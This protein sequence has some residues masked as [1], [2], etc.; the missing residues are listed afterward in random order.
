[1]QQ[2]T[3]KMKNSVILFIAIVFSLN[4][5]G[6]DTF[7]ITAVDTITGE[8]GSAGAS[9][10]GAPQIPMGCRILSDV[11]PGKGVIHTQAYYLSQNQNYARQLMLAGYSPEQ[12]IDSL[13]A[14]DWQ[15][16]PTIRQYGV[17][18]LYDGS[19]RK[20]AFTGE[21]CDDYK[22]HL[23]GPNYTIQ[24]NILLGQE[25][26]DSM[27]ARFLNTDGELACKLMA[28]LQGAKVIGA[29]TRCLNNGVS[30]LSAFI[31]VGQ[32][33]NPYNELYLDLNVPST[34]PGVDPIDSLQVLFDQWG[35]CITSAIPEQKKRIEI[36]VFP[37]PGTSIIHFGLSGLNGRPASLVVF[38]NLGKPVVEQ[39]VDSGLNRIDFN[40]KPGLYYYQ[41]TV[42]QFSAG[43]GKFI[44]K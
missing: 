31:R 40:F 13:I 5:K 21:N 39:S 38:S 20:A 22:N 41:V 2:N 18:D 24:G 29:D 28:A 43:N 10:I 23:I 25:I 14:N 27:E 37:N 15:N 4:L 30:S 1:M 8:V 9:C 44:V 7:S 32:P 42:D 34:L 33:D 17:I 16:N 35:G 19:A 11:L 12:I 26:L 36:L 6:Q 3:L